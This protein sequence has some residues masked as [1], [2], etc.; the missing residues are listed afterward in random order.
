MYQSILDKDIIF[1]TSKNKGFG[2]IKPITI[3][4]KR[5]LI[6]LSLIILDYFLFR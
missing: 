1:I 6:P 4:K 3:K 5:I 2:N